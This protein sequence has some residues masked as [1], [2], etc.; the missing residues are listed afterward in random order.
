MCLFNLLIYR[1][2][3]LFSPLVIYLLKKPGHLFCRLSQSRFSDWVPMMSFTIFLSP[4]FP[5]NSITSILKFDQIK[6]QFFW[7]KYIL[8][9]VIYFHQEAYVWLSLFVMLAASMIS[10]EIYYFLGR[11]PY[12][13]LQVTRGRPFSLSWI[14]PFLR[15]AFKAFADFTVNPWL[16]A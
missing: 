10:A 9:S 15:E 3:F 1:F 13:N 14:F 5:V 16:P 2:L 12:F 11:A 7:Q 4:V 6:V 8:G